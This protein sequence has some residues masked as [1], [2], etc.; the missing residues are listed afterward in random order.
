MVFSMDHKVLNTFIMVDGNV[1]HASA[2][3]KQ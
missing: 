1:K 2:K 3:R